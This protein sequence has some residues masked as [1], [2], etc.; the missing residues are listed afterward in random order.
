MLEGTEHHCQYAEA[1]GDLSGASI[2]VGVGL[3]KFAGAGECD[4]T[5][6][7]CADSAGD[8]SYASEEATASAEA[9]VL[10]TV[11]ST[12]TSPTYTFATGLWR[13]SNQ[14]VPGFAWRL[15]LFV[16][17]TFV[18]GDQVVIDD[19]EFDVDPATLTIE[20]DV[21][22]VTANVQ[23]PGLSAAWPDLDHS[24]SLSRWFMV[25]EFT[26]SSWEAN[27]ISR[28]TVNAGEWRFAF[29]KPWD[30]QPSTP[31]NVASIRLCKWDIEFK[32][33]TIAWDATKPWRGVD[34]ARTGGD[35][36]VFIACLYA[37]AATGYRV[38]PYAAGGVSYTDMIEGSA[39]GA[40]EKYIAKFGADAALLT[41]VEMGSGSQEGTDTYGYMIDRVRDANPSA[42][43]A[44]VMQPKYGSPNWAAN[45]SGGGKGDGYDFDAEFAEVYTLAGVKDVV[46]WNPA[47]L[48]QSIVGQIMSCE[49]NDIIHTNAN[50]TFRLV[51]RLFSVDMPLLA[52]TSGDGSVSVFDRAFNNT[53]FGGK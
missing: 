10:D 46:Y 14:S 7:K 43:I 40:M 34:V 52:R 36:P 28:I 3:L 29:F 1:I 8:P 53:V 38:L 12:A 4:V 21:A 42:S 11:E 47:N 18:F 2:T 45:P 15:D 13:V 41:Q 19:T 44:L 49:M 22:A 26:D 33:Y 39:W 16:P 32:E 24:P 30:A 31:A 35:G 23:N 17:S 6:Q 50:G 37:Y 27:E 20:A 5:P 51:D 25:V 9:V 48:T